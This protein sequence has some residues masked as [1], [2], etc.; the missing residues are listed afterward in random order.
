VL[1]L[2]DADYFDGE[3]FA[4]EFAQQNSRRVKRLH[5]PTADVFAVSV[6]KDGEATLRIMCDADS[7]VG[8]LDRPL[9]RGMACSIGAA[10]PH[11]TEPSRFGAGPQGEFPV[12]ITSQNSECV[13]QLLDSAALLAVLD[14][15]QLRPYE[16]VQTVQCLG[17]RFLH[18]SIGRVSATFDALQ[19]LESAFPAPK[20]AALPDRYPASLRPVARAILEWGILDDRE[21]AGMVAEAH[22]DSLRR[23][24]GSA[25]HYAAKIERYL[26]S[27][28]YPDSESA[29]RV[30][31]FVSAVAQ[32]QSRMEGVKSLRR[33]APK[34]ANH[35]E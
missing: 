4:R 19:R 3:A 31:A 23:L 12:F 26:S 34:R 7:V 32:A 24:L 16:Y 11:F 10:L 8:D 33:S 22:P 2:V 14:A 13:P 29:Q 27:T 1:K 30:R 5:M 20:Q 15:A 18:P 28:R 21:R 6:R 9:P 25:R 17:F 35:R